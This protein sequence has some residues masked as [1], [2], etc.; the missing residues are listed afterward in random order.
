MIIH[1]KVP[2]IIGTFFSLAAIWSLVRGLVLNGDPSRAAWGA[3]IFAILVSCVSMIAY[4]IDGVFCAIKAFKKIQPKFHA[5]LALMIAAGVVFAWAIL[6]TSLRTVKI[7][8]WYIIYFS[9]VIL[10]IIS[11]VWHFRDDT[12]II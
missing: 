9:I 6:S 10:E 5:T 3:G 2:A 8:A 12:D 11:I 7:V 1:T 4:A